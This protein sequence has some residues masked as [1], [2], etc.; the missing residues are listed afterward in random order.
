MCF[1]H[2]LFENEKKQ[3]RVPSVDSIKNSYL[4]KLTSVLLFITFKED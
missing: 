3:F 4:D 1:E 2:I